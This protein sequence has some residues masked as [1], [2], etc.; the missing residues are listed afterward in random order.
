M[1]EKILVVDDEPLV[2]MTIERALSKVGYEVRVAE[3]AGGFLD[4]LRAEGAPLLIMDL[5][6]GG[7]DMEA[8][9]EEA[10]RICPGSEIL[11]VSGSVPEHPGNFLEKPFRIDDLRQ[12][13][14]A[15][16]NAR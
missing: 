14:R 5:H 9:V 11:F 2:L 15:I 3:D 7:T 4:A 1:C 10:M 16:L 12:K 6:L 8:L 13:V